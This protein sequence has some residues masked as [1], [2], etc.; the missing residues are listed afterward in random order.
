MSRSPGHR[1]P[2][3]TL[4]WAVVIALSTLSL[5]GVSGLG[6]ASA[7][8][9][10]TCRNVS[11]TVQIADQTGPVSGT[12]CT[13]PGADTVQL[14]VPGW[15]YDRNY[16]DWPYKP[17]TYSYARAANSAGY[18][19]L[20]IDRPGTGASLHP[21]SL[22][23]TFNAN[24]SA[25]HDV[26]QALRS[27]ALGTRFTKVIEVG[28]SLGS[29]TVAQEAGQYQDVNAL[30]TTGFTHQVNY[31]NV[32][33]EVIAHDYPAMSDPRFTGTTT[34]PLDM[35]S[36]PGTRQSFYHDSDT[37]PGVIAEDE[38]LKAMD[39][40]VDFATAA[41]FNVVNV[42]RTLNVPVFV[43]T[44][45]NDPFFCGA[46]TADCSTAQA[47]IQHELPWY[48]P[49]ATIEAYVPPNT[50]HDVQLERSAPQSTEQ[51][52]AFSNQFVG[53]GN[54]ETGTAAGVR[55]AIPAPPVTQV[56]ALDALVGAAF[57]TAVTPVADTYT[58]LVQSIPG[59]G[60]GADPIPQLSQILATIANIDNT[61]LGTLPASL[62]GSV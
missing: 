61:L 54:G 13:P 57:T 28:H 24:V 52:L 60:N 2:W 18:A 1:R 32:A 44:A 42:D 19:T 49:N 31:L 33:A 20:A 43:V 16:F 55:P 53:P 38:Q 35:T 47:L 40:L 22:F 37:D 36:V 27:G 50:G 29:I 51:M 62:L 4:R 56:S 14:L 17:D 48:G 41:A 39:N 58:K 34:N 7:S 10:T 5:T 45:A 6:T 9:A 8:A 21:L 3:T 15:T 26:V 30:I 23:D 59:L 12:L 46:A 25:V 11:V